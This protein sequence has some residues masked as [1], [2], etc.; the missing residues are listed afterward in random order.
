MKKIKLEMHVHTRYSKDSLLSF[1]ALYLKCRICGIDYIAIT[2]HN[3]IDGAKK[4]EKYCKRH[5][6]KISVIVGEEIFTSE[7]EIIGLF[8]REKIEPYLSP[9]KTI[10]EIK[11]QGG[12]VYVPHPFDEKRKKTV[13]KEEVISRFNDKIDCIEIHNG[14]NIEKRYDRIQREISEKYHILGV[15]GSD[16]HTMIEIGRNYMIIDCLDN[17]LTPNGFITMLKQG[18][19]VEK[20]CIKIA[21]YITAI[22]KILKMIR[23]GQFNEVYHIIYRKFK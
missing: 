17:I 6:C 23:K 16:A 5:G 2:E 3:N 20:K 1:W 7:G 14:R 21:H 9:E 10:S 11:K 19:I 15:V 18:T 8:L 12:I 4:F 22:V 13:L